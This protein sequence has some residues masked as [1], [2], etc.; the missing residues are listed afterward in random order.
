[1]SNTARIAASG[2]GSV[3]TCHAETSLTDTD[4]CQPSAVSNSVKWLNCWVSSKASAPIVGT[5]VAKASAG[6]L[7]MGGDVCMVCDFTTF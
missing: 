7:T 6:A 1:M 4:A 5:G 3:Q 2:V